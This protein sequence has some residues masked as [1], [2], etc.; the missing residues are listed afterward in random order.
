MSQSIE[1]CI[2]AESEW[3]P[4]KL[5][6]LNDGT[7]EGNDI[8]RSFKLGANFVLNTILPEEMGLFAE[9][10]DNNK[11]F[12]YMKYQWMQADTEVTATTEELVH[13]Y[14]KSKDNG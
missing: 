3:M 14:L 1:Q 13:K 2:E 12:I 5:G 11:W 10:L 7:A 4:E 6:W 8:K 9:W